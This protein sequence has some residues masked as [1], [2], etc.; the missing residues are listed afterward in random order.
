MRLKQALRRLPR[1][2]ATRFAI[3]I[4]FMGLVAVLLWWRGP[5]WTAI[6]DAFTVVR[7]QWAMHAAIA[8]SPTTRYSPPI[9]KST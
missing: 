9:I 8:Y 1:S 2:S 5:S 3:T 7:W 6:G 4:I